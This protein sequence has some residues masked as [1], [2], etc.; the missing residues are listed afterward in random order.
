MFGGSP[1]VPPPGMFFA[2]SAICSWLGMPPPIPSILAR[3]AIGPR[4]APPI[5]FIMSAMPR[6]IFSNLLSSS[7]LVPEPATIRFAAVLQDVRVAPLFR[8]HGIDH[9]LR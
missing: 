1:P 8:R 9:R 4:L 5:A 3:P 7:T 2:I 6:C